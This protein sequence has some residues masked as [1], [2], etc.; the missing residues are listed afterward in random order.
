MLPD[1]RLSWFSIP[2]SVLLISFC[3]SPDLDA[4]T[5][6]VEQ[7]LEQIR[8]KMLEERAKL[9]TG[10]FKAVGTATRYDQRSYFKKLAKLIEVHQAFDLPGER[11]RYEFR[12]EVKVPTDSETPATDESRREMREKV[13]RANRIYPVQLV[14]SVKAIGY[15][16]DWSGEETSAGSQTSTSDLTLRDSSHGPT[17]PLQSR[18]TPGARG[19]VSDLSLRM[20]RSLEAGWSELEDNL[21]NLEIV[22]VNDQ[23]VQL[24]FWYERSCCKIEIDTRNGYTIRHL[25]RTY[26]DRE[27]QPVE[28]PFLVGTTSWK[29]VN[30]VWVPVECSIRY[31]QSNGDYRATHYQFIWETVNPD[32]ESFN[33]DLFTYRSLDGIFAGTKVIDRRGVA[34]YSQPVISPAKPKFFGVIGPNGKIV[35]DEELRALYR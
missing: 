8:A 14:K 27:G 1:R 7:R 2:F 4:Q 29:R 22:D 35:D 30:E 31:D 33:D 28:S 16:A 18:F 32:P 3:L 20:G 34:D 17:S 24:T 13:E 19:F 11:Q 25:E 15:S 21:L 23:I 26:L 5:N 6:D 10:S 9:K 12:S